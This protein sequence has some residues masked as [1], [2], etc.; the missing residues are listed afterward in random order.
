MRVIETTSL[1]SLVSEIP[2]NR[3]EG[4]NSVLSIFAERSLFRIS[5]RRI[6]KDA[7]T[8]VQRLRRF[9]ARVIRR[10]PLLPSNLARYLSGVLMHLKANKRLLREWTVRD[11]H[12]ESR[13]KLR[14]V[15]ACNSSM[16]VEI[17]TSRNLRDEKKKRKK[18]KENEVSRAVMACKLRYVTS[19]LIVMTGV[20]SFIHTMTSYGTGKLITYSCLRWF[21]FFRAIKPRSLN[22]QNDVARNK[23]RQVENH[24]VGPYRR[25]GLGR[26]RIF[27]PVINAYFSTR[28]C[29]IWIWCAAPDSQVNEQSWIISQSFFFPPP[30]LILNFLSKYFEKSRIPATPSPIRALIGNGILSLLL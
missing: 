7:Q 30:T 10:A 15:L 16:L 6:H 19:I 12:F 5:T 25:R 27:S 13:W 11:F 26:A 9:F 4:G 28:K 17:S 2:N 1:N 29:T 3:E 20:A 21:R 24:L 18:G 23:G 22:P 8:T 14:N